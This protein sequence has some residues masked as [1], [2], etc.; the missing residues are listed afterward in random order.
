[1]TSPERER[2]DRMTRG[3]LITWLL[4]SG[5]ALWLASRIV[6][7]RPAFAL[8]IGVA[9]LAWSAFAAARPSPSHNGVAV[10]CMAPG[11]DENLFHPFRVLL[12]HQPFELI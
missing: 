6:E 9:V 2:E 11:L 5:V 4:V 7:T 8:I 12:R 10:A 3:T 1:M